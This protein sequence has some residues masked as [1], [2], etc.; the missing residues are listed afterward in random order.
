MF[1]I[2]FVIIIVSYRIIIFA[3]SI[4]AIL[5]MIVTHHEYITGADRAAGVAEMFPSVLK[6]MIIKIEI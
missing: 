2:L 4:T 5:Y 1:L 3:T 6:K